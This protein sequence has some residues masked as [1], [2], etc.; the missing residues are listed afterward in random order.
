MDAD[1]QTL[2]LRNLRADAT[3]A[4]PIIWMLGPAGS[5]QTR[6]LAELTR[7]WRSAIRHELQPATATAEMLPFPAELPR[8]RFLL[9][10]GLNPGTSYDPA[11]DLAVM[12]GRPGLVLVTLA[13][14][15]RDFA[16]LAALLTRLRDVHPDWPILVAQTRLHE[17][18]PEGRQHPLPY[19]FD[20]DGLPGPEVPAELADTLRAQ[21]AA[22]AGRRLRFVPLDLTEPEQGQAVLDYGAEALRHA[23]A[24][25]APEVAARLEIRD[26]PEH[27]IRRQ[28]VLPW[29]AAAAASEAPPF[30]L[31]GGLPAIAF[32]AAMVRAIARR[33]GVGADGTVWATLASALG[34]SFL[35]RYGLGWLLRQGL[36]LAPPWGSAVAAA[37]SFA[38]TCGMGEAAIRLCREEAAGR[39][40]T[41]EALREAFRLGHEEGAAMHGAG[42]GSASF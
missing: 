10:V 34:G 1:G 39:Q 41:P 2:S 4:A 42:R 30:P 40:A 23:I 15:D 21:R 5:G 29:A 14:G 38:V 18:Y 33:F 24:L 22:L 25:L 19:A 13:A 3:A 12:E 17:L 20:A 28:V 16:P 36:K 26:D 31:L 6:L 35:L 32:Q 8:L 27:W 7:S 9:T 37:W 11:E